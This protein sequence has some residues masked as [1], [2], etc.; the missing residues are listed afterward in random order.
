MKI[1]VVSKYGSVP[2]SG[3]LTRLFYISKYLAKRGYEVEYYISDSNHLDNWLSEELIRKHET[4]LNMQIKV[5]SVLKYKS[6][7]SFIRVLS[8]LHFEIKLCRKILLSN[9]DIVLV[10]S[11]SIFSFLTGYLFK[12]LRKRKLIIDIRDIWPET[13]IEE[14][15]VNKWHPLVII[16]YWLQKLAYRNADLV[17]SSIPNLSLHI[18]EQIGHERPFHCLPMGFDSSDDSIQKSKEDSDDIFNSSMYSDK[19]IVGYVGSIGISNNLNTFIDYIEADSHGNMHFLIVGDGGLLSQ[20][21]KRLEGKTNVTFTGRVPKNMAR[22][23][24][25]T[26][27]AVYFSTHNSSIW[28]YGQ[29]LNK[30]LDYMLLAKPI[31]AAYPS[32]AYRSMIDEA[33]CGSFIVPDNEAELDKALTQLASKSKAELNRIGMR[34]RTWVLE[35]REYCYLVSKLDEKI[36]NVL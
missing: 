18:L 20:Y 13:L 5:L 10:S 4:S 24:L 2:G 23:L 27:D 1:S 28:R 19:L 30:V 17:V 36:N 8:W 22:A 3:T 7:K 9:N 32:F 12:K 14:G 33:K 21:K 26:C 15:G 11:P 25:E 31:V 34:G 16:M 35:N 29:S 6:Q